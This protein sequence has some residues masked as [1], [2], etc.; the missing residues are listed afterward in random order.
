MMI[1]QTK[2]EKCI[3][4]KILHFLVCMRVKFQQLKITYSLHFKLLIPEYFCRIV[5]LALKSYN[6]CNIRAH[7]NLRLCLTL[8]KQRYTE[9][10]GNPYIIVKSN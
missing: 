9:V 4:L 1:F 8:R 5:F 6:S 7:I 3:N 2:N 10:L